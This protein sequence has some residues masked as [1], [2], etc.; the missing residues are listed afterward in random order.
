MY[1]NCSTNGGKGTAS[2]GCNTSAPIPTLQ[3]SS[4]NVF[5][6]NSLPSASSSKLPVHRSFGGNRLFVQAFTTPLAVPINTVFDPSIGTK[7]LPCSNRESRGPKRRLDGFR[8]IHHTC[9]PNCAKGGT[10][11]LPSRPTANRQ[12]MLA[13]YGTS[14]VNKSWCAGT[15]TLDDMSFGVTREWRAHCHIETPLCGDPKCPNL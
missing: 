4:S 7:Y 6:V 3:P 10:A 11:R 13:A 14:H 15:S 1:P 8:N 12:C 2:C 5:G 9:S